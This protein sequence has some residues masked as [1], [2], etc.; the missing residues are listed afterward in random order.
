MRL[1]LN[2]S[3]SLESIRSNLLLVIFTVFIIAI[4]IS[5]LVGVHTAFGALTSSMVNN[6]STLGTN[7]FSIQNRPSTIV[8]GR[9]ERQ[10]RYPPISFDQAV[11]FKEKFE[12]VPVSITASGNMGA[13]IQH[14]SKRTNPTINVIGTDEN[15]LKTARYTVESG[16]AITPEDLSSNRKVV[17]IGDDIKRKLFPNEPATGKKVTINGEFF[18]VIGVYKEMG[19]SGSSGG[20]KIVNIPVTTLRVSYPNPNRTYTLNVY[21]DDVK[22]MDN[23]IEEATGT[24]RLIRKRRYD[25]ENDFSVTQSEAFAEQIMDNLSI[26]TT[27]ANAVAIVTLL[28]ASIA[29][30][31]IMLFSVTERTN[32][33][34]IRKA[35]GAPENSIMVQFLTEAVVIC[36][37]GGVAGVLLGLI[38]GNILSASLKGDF[39]VPWAWLGIGLLSCVVVGILSGIYPANKAAKLD[40][41]ES[42]RHE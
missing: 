24:M 37:L 4:G 35:L 36:L 40:P 14:Q 29:L 5:A 30:L 19:S 9:G 12:M 13:V 22:L 32:E 20:D 7:T 8:M 38:L 17:V 34:G 15:Y 11:S 18:T 41:I 10:V 33:I 26:I 16:R 2:V 39:V 42:L 28:G 21:V 25:Q 27:V 23:L 1:L 6:F 3:Q 31:N